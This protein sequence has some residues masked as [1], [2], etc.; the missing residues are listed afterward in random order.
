MNNTAINCNIIFFQC[1]R[2][3]QG[4]LFCE[5]KIQM[6]DKAGKWLPYNQG[7][8]QHDCKKKDSM[9]NGNSN[10]ISVEVLLLNYNQ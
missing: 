8:S 6:S 9:A 4:M 10:D 5:K 3:H 1:E 7:G 2:I